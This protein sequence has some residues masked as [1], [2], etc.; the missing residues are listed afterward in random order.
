MNLVMIGRFKA[1]A[2]AAEAKHAIDQLV[3][4]VGDETDLD[5]N[6]QRYSDT[7]LKLLEELRVH[8]V[9]PNELDQFRQDV[10]V[11]L[12][13]DRIEL[14]TD[15][16][17]VSAFLK[18]LLAKGGRIEVYSAHDYPDPGDKPNELKQ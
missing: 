2:D 6:T 12:K 8:S 5:C 13:G 17:E 1:L 7:M 4:Q 9:S 15:E 16:I 18:V 14:G 10:S 3:S 11:E